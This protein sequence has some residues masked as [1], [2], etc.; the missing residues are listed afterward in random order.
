MGFTGSILLTY[1]NCGDFD[2]NYDFDF[3]FDFAHFDLSVAI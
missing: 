3:D 2:F 1:P